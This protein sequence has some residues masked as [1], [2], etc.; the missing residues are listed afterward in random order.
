[1]FDFFEEFF[2]EGNQGVSFDIWFYVLVKGQ[3]DGELFLLGKKYINYF[4]IDLL[5]VLL[6]IF[7]LLFEFLLLYVYIQYLVIILVKYEYC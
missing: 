7:V 5:K 2:Y 4:Y 1:M 3:I 6:K